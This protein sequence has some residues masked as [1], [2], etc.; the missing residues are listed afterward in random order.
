MV[1]ID[2]V[3]CAA[4]MKRLLA[5]W[6]DGGDTLWGGATSV[7][8]GTGVNKEDDLRY[9]KSVALEVWLFGYEL[10]DTLI[11]FTKTELHVVTSSKKG[12]CARLLS[13]AHVHLISCI[14]WRKPPS[15]PPPPSNV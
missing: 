11:L 4:R 6:T 13:C 10:P 12:A 9:L 3:Q 8:V 15:S 2:A 14:M 5:S 7:M 1:T